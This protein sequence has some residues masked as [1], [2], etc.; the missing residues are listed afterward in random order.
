MA[1]R[2]SLG[3]KA[4]ILQKNKGKH[5]ERGSLWIISLLTNSSSTSGYSSGRAG[6]CPGGHH[7]HHH[8]RHFRPGEPDGFGDRRGGER[9]FDDQRSGHD[10]EE[11]AG[12]HHQHS[13]PSHAGHR[14]CG[15]RVNDGDALPQTS[16]LSQLSDADRKK[17]FSELQDVRKALHSAFSTQDASAVSGTQGTGGTDAV[18]QLF[19]IDQTPT[20]TARSTR[21]NSLRFLHRSGRTRW[22]TTSTATRTP[23]QA[24]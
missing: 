24:P 14:Y 3:K 1:G 4:R 16:R 9:R 15:E 8:K 7:H 18:S 10:P 13:G 2:L 12:R 22:D 11:R 21:A 6:R 17:V 23:H 19:S 5:Q 20:A